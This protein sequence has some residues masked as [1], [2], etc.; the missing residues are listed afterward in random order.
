MFSFVRGP[1]SIVCISFMTLLIVPSPSAAQT[2][3]PASTPP[4]PDTPTVKAGGTIFADYS[5]QQT[6][7]ITDADG[8]EVALSQFEITRAYINLTGNITRHIAFRLTTDI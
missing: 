1:W 6:P 2:Q 7:K 3:A 8:N 5:V 4:S